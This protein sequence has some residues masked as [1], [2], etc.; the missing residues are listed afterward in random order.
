MQGQHVQQHDG[1]PTLAFVRA[2]GQQ[3]SHSRRKCPCAPAQKSAGCSAASRQATPRNKIR[4]L[5][6]MSGGACGSRGARKEPLSAGIAFIWVGV[7][8]TAQVSADR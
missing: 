6:C 5:L 3:H 4:D 8:S 1:G 7:L 2:A